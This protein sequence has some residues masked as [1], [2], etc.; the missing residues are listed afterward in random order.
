MTATANFASRRILR[1]A[2]AAVALAIGTLQAQPTPSPSPSPSPAA[3]PVALADVVAAADAAVEQ[4]AQTSADIN[5]NQTS[6]NIA[7]DM[8]AA[9]AQIDARTA[10]TKRLLN[11]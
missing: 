10:E 6:T 7:R 1:S 3:T 8:P 2:L 11:P 9:I 5:S 4:L